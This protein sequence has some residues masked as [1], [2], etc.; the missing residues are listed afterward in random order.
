[1]AQGAGSIAHKVN[2]GDVIEIR[3]RT[4]NVPS[5]RVNTSQPFEFWYTKTDNDSTFTSTMVYKANGLIT[6][7]TWQTVQFTPTTGITLKRVMFDFLKEDLGFSGTKLE[8]DY[9]YI[10]PAARRPSQNPQNTILF[11]YTNKFTDELR[12]AG[13]VYNDRNYDNGNWGGTD[14]GTI[15]FNGSE[16]VV[17][18]VNGTNSF[19]V[20][21]TNSNASLTS[22]PLNYAPASKDMIQI[23]MKLN[24]L[25]AISGK[26]AKIVASYIKD[27]STNGVEAVDSTEL[28]KLNNANFNGEYFTVTAFLDDSF[29]TASV[30]N[31]LRI[32]FENVTNVSGKSGSVSIDY[33]AVGQLS[34]LPVPSVPCTVTFKDEAGNVLD[35]QTTTVGGSVSYGG[36][37]LTKAADRNNHYI[38]GG[39]KNA[40]G[41]VADLTKISG[42]SVFF[43]TYKAEA[44]G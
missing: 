18:V 8:I 28:V 39:W 15:T 37:A 36:A 11:D 21:T 4:S 41:A 9:M 20:Q 26:D 40:E 35:T 1:M 27:N 5:N 14:I 43:A 38:F 32:G 12:Y 6:E 23:R 10:G 7:G 19:S 25:Q 44:H 24:D 3:Y 29:T 31:A 22:T 42:D 34:S 13:F 17:P 2:S 16:M 33:I 30:I